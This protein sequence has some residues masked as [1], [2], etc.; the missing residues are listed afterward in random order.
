M[1]DQE[2]ITTVRRRA[3][4]ESDAVARS[5]TMAT[6]QTLGERLTMGEVDDLAVQL[7]ESLADALREH[8]E[9]PG[10]F[11]FDEFRSRVDDRANIEGDSPPTLVRAVGVTLAEA[12][13][14]ELDDAR[15]QLP[16]AYDRLFWMADPEEFLGTVRRHTDL[17]S[18]AAARDTTIATLRVLGERLTHGEARQLAVYLPDAFAAAL[19]TSETP[20]TDYDIVEFVD[21]VA[22]QERTESDESELADRITDDGE[23]DTGEVRD[24]VRAVMAA[25]ADAVPPAE[26]DDA[27]QQLPDAYSPLLELVD[28][29]DGSAA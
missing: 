21:R 22:E 25:L 24:H 14:A 7:P 9:V 3:N 5:V 26:F 16:P 8:G 17:E 12:V 4:L 1:D 18:R 29:A 11:S 20:A 13:G 27:L 10:D 28:R 19:E 15:A 2:F 6:L 23:T